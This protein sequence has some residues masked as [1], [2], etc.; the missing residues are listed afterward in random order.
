[1]GSNKGRSIHLSYNVE[2]RDLDLDCTCSSSWMCGI[3]VL[4]HVCWIDFGLDIWSN[5]WTF[6]FCIIPSRFL[7]VIHTIALI[8]VHLHVLPAFFSS[9]ISTSCTGTG[10]GLVNFPC[11]S[12]CMRV[13]NAPG[14][15]RVRVTRVPCFTSVPIFSTDELAQIQFGLFLADDQSILGPP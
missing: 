2:R 11:P 15:W 9:D 12:T 4:I 3:L 7:H 5:P 10:R 14:Q 6:I 13:L 1:M 8:I